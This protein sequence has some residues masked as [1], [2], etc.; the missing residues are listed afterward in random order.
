MIVRSVSEIVGTQRDV[1]GDGWKSRRFLLAEDGLPV[2]VHETTVEAGTELR[3][4]YEKHRETVYCV[5]GEGSL[6]NMSTGER[7][8]LAPG[9]LYSVDVGDDHVIRAETQVKFLCIFD[10][11]LRGTET[12]E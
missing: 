7:F 3:F 12:A 6:E 2:S 10:P 4:S 9:T 5:E 11:P 8:T 1:S